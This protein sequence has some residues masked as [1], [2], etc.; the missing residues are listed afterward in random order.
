MLSSY[1]LHLAWLCF[2]AFIGGGINA[3]AGGGSLLSFPAL[4]QVGVLPI[5]ANA[6][7]TVALLPGQITS[8]AAYRRDLRRYHT[9]LPTLLTA[10]FVGGVLGAR[11]LAGNAPANVFADGPLAIAHCD[12]AICT[13]THFSAALVS[14][15]AFDPLERIATDGALFCFRSEFLPSRFMSVFLEPALAF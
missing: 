6:T 4:L 3:I 9:M 12:I 8:A 14:K 2:A 11:L 7:N 15:P 10:A 13:W 5:H 1:L